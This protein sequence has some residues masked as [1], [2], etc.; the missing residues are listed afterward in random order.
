MDLL[1]LL[2]ILR[3][4]FL[5]ILLELMMVSKF[6]LG[7]QV[8]NLRQAGEITAPRQLAPPQSLSS[9]CWRRL[10]PAA[11]CVDLSPLNQDGKIPALS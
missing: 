6:L 7:A 4:A 5:W 2:A 3:K 9:L 11:T 10:Q 1:L 8:K